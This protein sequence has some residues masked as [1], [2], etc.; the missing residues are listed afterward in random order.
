MAVLLEVLRDEKKKKEF[1]KG[2]IRPDGSPNVLG[3]G[4]SVKKN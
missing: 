4:G 3:R 1:G 2:E